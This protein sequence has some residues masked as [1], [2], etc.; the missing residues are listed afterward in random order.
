M[1]YNNTEFYIQDNWKV[2]NRLTLDYGIRFTRQQPQYDQF[3]QMSNFFPDQWS[4]GRRRSSTSRAAATARPRARATSA[5]RWIRAPGRS[6]CRPPA[7]PTRRSLIGTP[8]PGSGNPLNGIHQAGDGISKYGYTWPT[9]VF[10]PRFGAAYDVTGNAEPHPPRRRRPLL[11]SSGRQHRVLDPGQPADRH[12]RR[13]CATAVW[14]RSASGLSPARCRSSSPSSTTRRCRRRGSG[15]P[16]SRWRCPWASSL[17]VSYVGNHGY[18]R[19]GGLQGGN[20][21]NLNAVDIGAAFL[22]QNQDPT[23]GASTVPGADGLQRQPAA[24]VPRARQHQPEHDRVLGH[25][26]LDP[27]VVPAPVPERLLVR[28]ELHARPL[29]HGQHRPAEASA[30]RAGRHDLAARRSGASTRSC[31]R[32]STSSGTSSR[33]TPCGTCRTSRRPAAAPPRRWSATSS[34]TGSSRA[35]SPANS[36]NRY[37]LGYSYQTNGG[38]REPDRLAGLR[39][40]DRLR[41]RSGLGLLGQPVRAVQRRRR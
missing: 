41:R 40:P 21:V 14:R 10:G 8:I 20:V 3:Q 11:R 31:S 37:D 25:V 28:C 36:G 13:T 22:P 4:R 23:L 9:L 27:D 38:N 5:T 34:T 24:G 2:N 30:A 29:A 32:T 35:S 12:A 1:I 15:R 33:R 26:P 6:S 17:D 16:A 39:R 19:L 18:N 7:R